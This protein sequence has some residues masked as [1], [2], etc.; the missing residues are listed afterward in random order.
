VLGPM[1]RRSLKTY[2]IPTLAAMFVCLVSTL[3][4]F[5]AASITVRLLDAKTGKPLAKTAVTLAVTE[6]G[7]IIFQ[8]HSNTNSNGLAVLSLPEPIPERISLS[9]GT[10][11]LGICSDIAFPASDIL[12]TGLVSKN[13]CYAGELPHPVSAR[14]GEIVLF[15]SPVSLRERILREIP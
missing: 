8:S 11:D 1:A 4:L 10:P 2:A 13:R 15:G 9:Y 3:V 6:N 12:T 7:K 5:A 14:P